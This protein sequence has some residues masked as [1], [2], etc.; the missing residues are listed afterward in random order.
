MSLEPVG[1]MTAVLVVLSFA[2]GERVAVPAFILCSLLGASAAIN[3]SG[4]GSIQP[5]HVLLGAASATVMMQ[6]DHLKRMLACLR[7]PNPGFW[8]LC[9]LLYGVLG[10]IFIPRI[11]AGSLLVNAIGQSAYGTTFSQVPLGPTT[12]NFTQSIYFAGDL[13]CFLI[14]FSI[15]STDRGFRIL[16]LSLLAYCVGDIVLA[17]AD[18]ATYQTG[19]TSI[20][21][22]IRNASYTVY[23][24][25][26]VTSSKRI[27][28]SFSEAS[29]FA[30]AS[31]GVFGFATQLWS[32]GFRP[33]LTLS[34]A[35]AILLLLLFSTASTAYVSLP[36]C[37]LFLFATACRSLFKVDAPTNALL[38]IVFVPLLCGCCILAIMLHTPTYTALMDFLDAVIFN[39][40][41]SDSGIGRANVNV[42]AWANFRD[43]VGLGLGIGSVRA[44]SFVLAVAANLGVVGGVA[45]AAFIGTALFARGDDQSAVR[46]SVR[47][48]ARVACLSLIAA[49][50]VS[51]ALID[52]GLPFFCFAGLAASRRDLTEM[53][54]GRAV[55]A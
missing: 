37:L 43:S 8:L 22:P 26:E 20:L 48:A 34:I 2:K 39:K 49:A 52:L 1:I 10:A 31:I 29:A 40:S 44:F 19:T 38:F 55:M 53:F 18:L 35:L 12:G 46:A 50:C 4:V 9:A 6:R 3:G 13:L 25:S 41:M 45:Y 42:E 32:E 30:A 7:F 5:A 51:G 14:C 24:D 17:G 21:D 36:F 15:A 54:A 33:Y 11:A 16:T 28:G 23:V 47:S 27:I